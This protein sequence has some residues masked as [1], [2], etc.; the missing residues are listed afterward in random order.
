MGCQGALGEVR[1]GYGEK[2]QAEGLA[3][4]AEEGSVAREEGGCSWNP[5]T[6]SSALP[7]SST[8][9]CRPSFSGAFPCQAFLRT[10]ELGVWLP[11]CP[12]PCPYPS[13]P[14]PSF[15]GSYEQREEAAGSFGAIIGLEGNR[16]TPQYCGRIGG[17]E[18]G[19]LEAT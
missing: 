14:P 10:P 17:G 11:S 4:Q 15:W 18:E 1:M 8:Q 6:R 16:N 2:A 5:L 12:Y 7:S 3:R 9:A 13:P 19:G